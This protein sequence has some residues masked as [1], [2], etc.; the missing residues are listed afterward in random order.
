[1]GLLLP[2]RAD[3]TNG[4]RHRSGAGDCVHVVRIAGRTDKTQAEESLERDSRC[5]VWAR[6]TKARSQKTGSEYFFQ[7]STKKILKEVLD[8]YMVFEANKLTR[9]INYFE[10]ITILAP[11]LLIAALCSS[12]CSKETVNNGSSKTNST[13]GSKCVQLVS[14]Y[15]EKNRGWPTTEYL[16]VEAYSHDGGRSFSVMHQ[17]DKGFRPVGGGKSF[18]VQLDDSCTKVFRELSYQ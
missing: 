15:I 14:E 10:P 1:M 13:V 7:L 12:A 3:K 18:E 2:A 17:D 8:V 11:L 16:I 4:L 9:V 5:P 6:L